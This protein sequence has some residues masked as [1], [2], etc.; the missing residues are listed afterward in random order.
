MASKIIFTAACGLL[1]SF[2]L[3]AQSEKN[4][5]YSLIFAEDYVKA[6]Q[7]LKNEKWIAPQIEKCGLKPKEVTSIIFP[8]LIR[9]NSIQDKIETFALESLYVLYGKDYANFS[10]SEFQIKP[11]FA[12]N[13]E[14]D[15]LKIFGEEKLKEFKITLADTSQNRENSASRLTRIKSR[16]GMVDYLCMFFL[17]ME[18]KYPNWKEE[19]QKIKFFASAFNCGYRKSKTEIESFIT[20]TF[21]YTGIS[22]SKKY[23]YASIAWYYYRQP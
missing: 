23:S 11:S 5:N 22:V 18:K 7:F 21:F 16:D 19:E 1:F 13:I 17:I 2:G 4:E 9:Y 3:F 12:E 6:E 20:K 8:E 14:I 15:F 10:V